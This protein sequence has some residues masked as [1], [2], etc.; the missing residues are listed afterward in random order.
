M[1][2]Q[3]IGLNPDRT[4][5]WAAEQSWGEVRMYWSEQKA[6]QFACGKWVRDEHGVL[7]YD[8][9]KKPYRTEPRVWKVS[10]TWEE[11]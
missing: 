8:E 5:F 6:R 7:L 3:P 10:M 9:N 1:S 11:V 4:E 2:A